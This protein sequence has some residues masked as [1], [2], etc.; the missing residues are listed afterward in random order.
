MY[1]T[2][3]F[4]T[5]VEIEMMLS[6][7]PMN[8]ISFDSKQSSNRRKTT[9]KDTNISE[10]VRSNAIRFANDHIQNGVLSVLSSAKDN[11]ILDDSVGYNIDS[12]VVSSFNKGWGIQVNRIGTSTSSMYGETYIEPYKD[13]L[14]EL[15]EVGLQNLSRKMNA[16]MMRN[17]L[18]KL[19]PN[20]ISIPGKTEIKKYISQLFSKSKS[21]NDD[22][23]VDIEIDE[24]AEDESEIAP[25]VNWEKCLKKLVELQ[26]PSKEHA[27]KKISSIKAVIKHRV[28]RS[29]VQS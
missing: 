8:I 15:F 22:N 2:N 27:K 19:F 12:N 7:N 10:D 14:K 16:A 6:I 9:F 3:S 28:Q 26:L 25:R 1:P 11:P 13:K 23:E 29:I 20:V 17:K 24:L 4:I 21:N 18:K 5:R